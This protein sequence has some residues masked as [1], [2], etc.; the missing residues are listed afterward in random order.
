MYSLKSCTGNG[1]FSRVVVTIITLFY[2][3]IR[4]PIINEK[5]KMSFLREL[6]SSSLSQSAIFSGKLDAW[7]N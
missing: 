5:L 4:K 2:C 3:V 1:L 6:T 7:I